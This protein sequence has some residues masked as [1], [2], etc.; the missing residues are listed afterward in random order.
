MPDL[1]TGLG[2]RGARRDRPFAGQPFP[3]VVAAVAFAALLA[4]AAQVVVQRAVAALLGPDVAVDGFVTDREQVEA[5]QSFRHLLGAPIFPEQ[6]LDQRPV[7]RREPLIAPRAG[8]ST[9]RI[10]VDE[11]R[12]IA[13]VAKRAV[14]PDLA[15]D[16]AAM[17]AEHT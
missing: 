13:S 3:V 17:T 8:S 15:T 16:R 9:A 5:A 10:P 14:A 11:L 12:P 6:L 7:G 4:G 2:R 1:R